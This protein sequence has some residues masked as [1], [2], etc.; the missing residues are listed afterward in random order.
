MDSENSMEAERIPQQ[1]EEDLVAITHEESSSAALAAELEDWQIEMIRDSLEQDPLLE[2]KALLQYKRRAD[3]KIDKIAPRLYLG[4]RF[5]AQDFTTLRYLGVQAVVNVAAGSVDNF[6]PDVFY[7]HS[8]SV[9]DGD[10]VDI[11]RF[12][13]DAADFIANHVEHGA[14][15][16][17]CAGGYSRSPTVVIA[18][19]IKHCGLSLGE[20]HQITKGGRPQV[21]PNNG[22]MEQLVKFE[23]MHRRGAAGAKSAGVPKA[24]GRA[25]KGYSK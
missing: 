10:K 7:Y 1:E 23:S 17:H 20:A 25:G 15:F 2:G 9:D 12:L 19:L 5:E 8:I 3:T 6:Y 18:Y 13:D 21:K 24:K 16:V 4:N 14:C 11:Y 22:F